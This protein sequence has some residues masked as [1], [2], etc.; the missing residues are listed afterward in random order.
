MRRQGVSSERRRSSC[1]SW[2]MAC[3][4]SLKQYRTGLWTLWN[5]RFVLRMAE[6]KKKTLSLCQIIKFALLHQMTEKIEGVQPIRWAAEKCNH[7]V[8]KCS[9]AQ[10]CRMSL[11][12]Y[13]FHWSMF[14][15]AKDRCR[16]KKFL[17]KYTIYPKLTENVPTVST[18][19]KHTLLQ[20]NQTAFKTSEKQN[21]KKEA[22]FF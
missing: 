18:L 5:W 8:K 19:R 13:L 21:I 12:L 7:H 6:F 11:M 16:I 17:T 14:F 3:I 2:L 10:I 9:Q 20:Y 4:R 22:Y 15:M 1:S